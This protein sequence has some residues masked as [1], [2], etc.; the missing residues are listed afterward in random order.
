MPSL[1]QEP[2]P[3][4]KHD[5]APLMFG[6]QMHE[7]TPQIANLA[8]EFNQYGYWKAITTITV[9]NTFKLKLRNVF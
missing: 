8:V 7:H 2:V 9:T 6:V 5:H 3:L 1:S 4:K